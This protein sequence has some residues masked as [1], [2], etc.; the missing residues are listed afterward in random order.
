MTDTDKAIACELRVAGLASIDLG[1]GK[2]NQTACT[3]G[4]VEP[5]CVIWMSPD[6]NVSTG[7]SECTPGPFIATRDSDAEAAHSIR[8]RCTL[9]TAAGAS[10][11]HG[12]GELV[13]TNEV[14]SGQWNVHEMVRN[15]FIIHHPVTR[16]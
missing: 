1:E 13:V 15:L 7:V 4:Q 3:A 16:V 2:P 8:G 12:P 6:C 14:W 11:K 5:S 10:S 9:T